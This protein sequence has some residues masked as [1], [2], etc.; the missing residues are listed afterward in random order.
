MFSKQP[1]L[2]SEAMMTWLKHTLK[3][4]L[5]VTI[6]WRT[7]C[8]S[9]LW[10]LSDWP[11]GLEFSV[12]TGWLAVSFPCNVNFCSNYKLNNASKQTPFAAHQTI[13]YSP[14]LLTYPNNLMT[15]GWGLRF[16]NKDNSERRS[17]FS[18]WSKEFSKKQKR[19]E[20]RNRWRHM[21]VNCDQSDP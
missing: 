11:W 10:D 5:I 17:I 20:N 13:R 16:F 9:L 19:K 7:D 15:C 21:A 14:A 8:F 1:S 6:F 2:A 3:E 12:S 18:E 4:I